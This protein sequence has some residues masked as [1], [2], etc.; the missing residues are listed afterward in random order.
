[1]SDIQ[2]NKRQWINTSD[3]HYTG[4]IVCVDAHDVINRSKYVERYVFMEISDCNG[5]VRIHND[6]NLGMVDYID[7]LKTIQH[8]I[9]LFID[10]LEKQ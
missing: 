6:L 3:S 7:K 8:E 9:Q 5:K 10:H 4:S 2:Y 1:M